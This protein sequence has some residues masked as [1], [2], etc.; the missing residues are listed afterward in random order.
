MLGCTRVQG[1]LV[2]RP[3]RP[4]R[5]MEFVDSY[6]QTLVLAKDSAPA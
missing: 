6:E 2:A 1:Y 4:E 3:L 5:V